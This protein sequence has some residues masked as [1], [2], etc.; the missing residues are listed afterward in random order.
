[1]KAKA[2]IISGWDNA[3]SAA[4][5]TVGKTTEEGKQ[6]SDLWKN[7]MCRAEH[8]P[9]REVVYRVECFDMPRRAMTHLV[10]HHEGIEKYVETSRPDRNPNASTDTV[11]VAFTINAQAVIQISKS[12]LCGTSWHETRTSWAR[13]LAAINEVDPTILAWCQPRCVRIGACPEPNCCGYI[14]TPSY[15][16]SRDRYLSKFK[17]VYVK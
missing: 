1:M 7:S 2:R 10:R 8:S 5:F 15:A 3:L 17:E 12:R 13:I 16:N 6:P 9:L 14:R 11:D 4:R